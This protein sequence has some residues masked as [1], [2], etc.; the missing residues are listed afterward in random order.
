[1]GSEE[2]KISKCLSFAIFLVCILSLVLESSTR[3]WSEC[4]KEDE[5]PLEL[6]SNK[7]RPETFVVCESYQTIHLQ[8]LTTPNKNS[9]CISLSISGRNDLRSLKRRRECENE[10]CET[11]GEWESDGRVSESESERVRMER[12]RRC[13]WVIVV[14]REEVFMTSIDQ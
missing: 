11:V 7:N 4:Y 13:T 14:N 8:T 2:E 12:E 6:K 10:N 5:R 1:V 3:E 9:S